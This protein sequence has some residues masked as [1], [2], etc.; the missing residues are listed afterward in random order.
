MS[1]ARG[2]SPEGCL[3]VCAPSLS[4][5]NWE[6]RC[7]GREAAQRQT[8]RFQP[9]L[10]LILE[11]PCCGYKLGGRDTCPFS[12]FEFSQYQ[13]PEQVR[14]FFATGAC[15][16]LLCEYNADSGQDYLPSAAGYS[17]EAQLRSIR[18]GSESI[19]P[20]LPTP[21]RS[22]SLARRT[23]LPGTTQAQRHHAAALLHVDEERGSAFFDGTFPGS[24]WH[25]V[26]DSGTEI[27]FLNFSKHLSWRRPYRRRYKLRYALCM[28]VCFETHGHEDK[29]WNLGP[30]PTGGGAQHLT[31][32]LM[33][34]D[35]CWPPA[36]SAIGL[37]AL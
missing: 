22:R 34:G 29:F 21:P 26:A 17:A 25:A 11:V 1:P 10:G 3:A 5:Q 37:D 14:F 31:R 15:Q 4:L 28:S 18:A 24:L 13:H 7:S 19:R 9:V 30:M 6:T 27:V 8:L 36:R 12:P 32:K 33:I 20:S 23:G 2:R 16:Y 35:P